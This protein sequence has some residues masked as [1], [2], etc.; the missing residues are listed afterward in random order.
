MLLAQ[1]WRDDGIAFYV[2]AA[3]AAGTRPVYTNTKGDNIW[4]TRYYYTD[5]AEATLRGKG[6]TGFQVLTAAAAD[7]Q[8]LM[9]VFYQNACGRSHD[10]LA[11]GKARFERARARRPAPDLRLSHWAG[12]TGPTTLVV[13]ALAEGCPYQGFFGA[14]ARARARRL[15]R[16]GSR[17]IS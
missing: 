15:S 9:R 1:S 11:A 16:R 5:G 6:E 8:P 3:A 2:P 10:E 13:E 4:V 14:A 7:A 12:I 17:S